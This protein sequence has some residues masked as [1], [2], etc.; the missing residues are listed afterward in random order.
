MFLAL[1]LY[2]RFKLILESQ[3]SV[4]YGTYLVDRLDLFDTYLPTYLPTK[5]A[6][7]AWLTTRNNTIRW[8]LPRAS[9]PQTRAGYLSWRAKLKS[10][11]AQQVSDLLTSPP[12]ITSTPSGQA[13]SPSKENPP[14]PLLPEPVIAHIAS[15]IL[16]KDLAGNEETQA[17]E[18]VA[19]L[20]FLDDQLDGFDEREDVDEDKVVG[21]LKKTWG[22]MSGE[23][24]RMALE[25][26][27]SE[28]ARGL[29]ARA[30]EE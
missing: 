8:Q 18:D 4:S 19:C 30:L 6:G 28:R 16:K 20:V 9:F 11:A 29:V 15:L 3:S 17:L 27:L 13:V 25:M 1:G 21:I 14:A 24:R 26:E 23:G 12:P 22:K 7:Q 10:L 2:A 5:A